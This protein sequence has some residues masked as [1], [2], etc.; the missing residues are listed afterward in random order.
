M[1]F[2]TGVEQYI[3]DIVEISQIAK[4]YNI[5]FNA[6]KYATEMYDKHKNKYGS[7]KEEKY[8]YTRKMQ[9]RYDC[10]VHETNLK[11]EEMI[12]DGKRNIL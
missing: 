2:N 3:Q 4:D 8:E 7:I 10:I 6:V 1:T 5:N 12:C 9:E 11:L